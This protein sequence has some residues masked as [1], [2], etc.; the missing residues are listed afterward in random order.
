MHIVTNLET[1]T[2]VGVLAIWLCL[3][4]ELSFNGLL[5]K[6]LDERRGSDRDL[7]LKQYFAQQKLPKMVVDEVVSG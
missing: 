6:Y 2:V 1:I 5:T 3:M 7:I 4:S